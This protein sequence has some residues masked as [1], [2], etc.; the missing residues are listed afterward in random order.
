MAADPTSFAPEAR[1]IRLNTL[2]FSSLACSLLAALGAVLAKQWI[3]GYPRGAPPSTTA[4]ERA[5]I[6]Q[7]RFDGISSWRFLAVIDFLPT[8]IQLSCLL[9][10][11]GL[12]DFLFMLHRTVGIVVT[13]ICSV[14]FILI[15]V[16]QIAAAISPHCP[17]RTP[18]STAAAK[19]VVWTTSCTMYLIFGS[20]GDRGDLWTSPVG[21]RG[22]VIRAWKWA[23]HGHPDRLGIIPRWA[24]DEASLTK[25]EKL[26][27]MNS[28]ALAWLLRWAPGEDTVVDNA[29]LIPTLPNSDICSP[30]TETLPR[31]CRLFQSFFV[32]DD[33]SDTPWTK[34]IPRKGCD[35]KIKTVGR[36]IHRILIHY[37]EPPSGNR[38]T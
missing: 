24:S 30:L 13:T 19:F 1:S 18:F 28:K 22:R 37:P 9:F 14:G 17:F 23:R 8:L 20:S 27:P 34:I 10:L 36:A 25:D 16:S 12:C 38:A 5:R 29:A 7:I 26:N 32:I 33:E 31:L 11:I 2:W 6:R 15:L 4:F 35:E 21:W 3:V